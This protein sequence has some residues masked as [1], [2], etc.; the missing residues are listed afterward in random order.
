M[1]YGVLSSKEVKPGKLTGVKRFRENLVFW[2]S[3]SG[4]VQCISDVCCHRGAALHIG[5]HHGDEIACPF[6]G[7][8]YN[9]DG[10]VTLIPAN[11]KNTPVSEN[12]KVKSYKT[13]EKDGII[14]LWY[15]EGEPDY[16]PRFFEDLDG[17][18]YSEYKE[19][20]TVHYTRAIENQLDPIHLPFVHRT[21][22]GRGNKTIVDGPLIKW[23]D[24]TMYFYYV[25]NR[26]DDGTPPKKPEEFNVSESTVYLEVQLPNLWQNHITE[27]VRVTAVFAPVDEENTDIYIR[28]YIKATKMKAFDNLIAKMGMP[29]NVIILHQ[30]KRVVET[31]L[32]K[33]TW[34]SMGE[35]LVQGDL[36]IVEFRKFHQKYRLY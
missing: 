8:R 23:I 27:N 4:E 3:T 26:V 15:G 10:K 7:F 17:M 5:E 13:Y 11:G 20:W 12:F 2:R 9:K 1:W 29:F 28:F 32:P 24:N 16:E 36:P 31:Q 25:K 6:H 19:R 14:Y 18:V 34:L 35:N 33:K 30:D 21:T 22:I